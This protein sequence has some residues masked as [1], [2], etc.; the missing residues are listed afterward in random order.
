MLN[1]RRGGIFGAMPSNIVEGDQQRL[2]PLPH[3][4][5]TQQQ[6]APP[7]NKRWLEGGKF[8]AKDGIGLVL[9]ALGDAFSG[10]PTTANMIWDT[11]NQRRKVEMEQQQY[12]RKREDD[13]ADWQKQFDYERANPKPVNND[14]QRDF[15]FIRGTL[16]E[17]AANQYLRNLGDPMVTVPLPNGQ[18][19]SGPR[20]GMG[21]ALGG[22]QA[23]QGGNLPTVS[24]QRSYDLIPAGSQ[25]RDPSGQIRTKGGGASNGTGSFS[26]PS[27][28]PL[29]PPRR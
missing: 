3:P 14:T 22:G 11:T 9:G 5:P 15:E 24:D 10:R 26:I 7:Q 6:P 19:Y 20:S 16:G 2:P 18:V 25:Y 4:F 23:Q 8:T 29:T 17:E 13:F 1:I 21:S 12:Q 27:G 28:N